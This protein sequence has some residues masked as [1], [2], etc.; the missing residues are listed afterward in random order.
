MTTK[1]DYTPEEWDY[2]CSAPAAA[3]MYITAADPRGFDRVREMFA[4]AHA[5]ANHPPGEAAQVLVDSLTAELKNRADQSTDSRQESA[6]GNGSKAPEPDI[7]DG[8][9]PAGSDA[10]MERIRQATQIINAKAD[11]AEARAYKQWLLD[12][13]D[14]TANAAVEGGFLGI[15]GQRVTKKEKAALEE[16][17]TV[18]GI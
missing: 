18:L 16:L 5:M 7:P 13:A 6:Q 4:T 12:I 10:L 11:A 2:L 9:L 14:I 8:E 17:K 3:G 1:K 15:G